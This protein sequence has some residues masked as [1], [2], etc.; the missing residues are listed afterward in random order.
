MAFEVHVGCLAAHEFCQFVVHDF[1]HQLLWFDGGQ[2]V[3]SECFLLDGIGEGFCN[4]VVYVGIE[5]GATYVFQCFGDIDF[6][7]LSFAFQ[8]LER[9]FEAF[10]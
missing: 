5:Q 10:A 8:Y 7:N 2:Y 9:P 4:L 3:L 6:C 1:H